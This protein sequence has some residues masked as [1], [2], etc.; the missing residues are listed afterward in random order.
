M[1]SVFSK[2]ARTA[3][4]SD[5]IDWIVPPR[6]PTPSILAPNQQSI[7]TKQKVRPFKNSQKK[8]KQFLPSNFSKNHG[9]SANFQAG[10]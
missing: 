3:L 9:F 4:S 10:R 5:V 1:V 2:T 6:S 7:F 8:S